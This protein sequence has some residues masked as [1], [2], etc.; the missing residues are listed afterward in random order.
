M[1]K[2]CAFAIMLVLAASSLFIS[3]DNGQS[4]GSQVQFSIPRPFWGTWDTT[5]SIN[6]TIIISDS[7]IIVGSISTTELMDYAGSTNF[8]QHSDGNTYIYSYTLRGVSY[9]EELVL[10]GDTLEIREYIGNQLQ[11]I[12]YY[13]KT[14]EPS[15]ESNDATRLS[16]MSYVAANN[17]VFSEDS[18]LSRYFSEETYGTSNGYRTV[19]RTVISAY[20]DTQAGIILYPDSVITATILQDTSDSFAGGISK[21]DLISSFSSTPADSHHIIIEVPLGGVDTTGLVV[22]FDDEPV[23]RDEFTRIVIENADMTV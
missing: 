5:Q 15:D 21:L 13:T 2:R 6:P 20:T 19:S 4:P 14:A 3:C 7:D 18:S 11:G 23:D 12:A 9:R 10:A 22:L 8:Y 1:I 16:A 17:I